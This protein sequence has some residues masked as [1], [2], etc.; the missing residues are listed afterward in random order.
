MR[1]GKSCESRHG[2]ARPPGRDVG[3]GVVDALLQY[4]GDLEE[5]GQE[6]SLGVRDFQ[7]HYLSALQLA[8]TNDLHQSIDAAAGQCGDRDSVAA[9]HVEMLPTIGLVVH[10]DHTAG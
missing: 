10:L 3:A 1:C 7:V 8:R 5:T 2:V 4:L 9:T 6:P